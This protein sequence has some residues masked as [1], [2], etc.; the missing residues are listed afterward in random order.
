MIGKLSIPSNRDSKLY[1]AILFIFG[2]SMMLGGC[3][4]LTPSEIEQKQETLDTMAAKAIEGLIKEDP[5]LKVELD[6]AVGYAVAN[7]KLTKVP[8]VGAGGGEGVL[9]DAKTQERRYFTVSRFDLGGGWGVRSYKALMVIHSEKVLEEFKGGSWK[10][11]SGAEASAGTAATEGSALTKKKQ[12]TMHV[13]ADGGASATV[14][15]RVVHANIDDAL[16][17]L[18]N[19]KDKR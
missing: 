13:L 4:A 12:V 14:T 8:V 2:L 19:E 16:T 5:A 15:V 10:F 7:M 1:K 11:E 3:A 9:V 17:Y 6:K 18:P